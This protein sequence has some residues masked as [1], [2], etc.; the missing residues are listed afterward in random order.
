MNENE[1]SKEINW[2]Q[3]LIG[4]T[5][6]ILQGMVIG[7]ANLNMH[8]TQDQLIETAIIISKKTIEKLKKEIE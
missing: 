7:R 3:E 8:F 4:M 1:K 6:S 5:S 2:N